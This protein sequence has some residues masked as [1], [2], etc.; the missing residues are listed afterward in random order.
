MEQVESQRPMQQASA[1]KARRAFICMLEMGERETRDARHGR[2]EHSFRNQKPEIRILVLR[3]VQY[4]D[5]ERGH[6]RAYELKG[7]E[8]STFNS[9]HKHHRHQSTTHNGGPSPSMSCAVSV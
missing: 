5:F 7:R 4:L 3:T 9:I 6:T 1:S 2:E 8:D